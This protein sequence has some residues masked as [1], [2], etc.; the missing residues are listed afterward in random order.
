MSLQKCFCSGFFCYTIM[1][2]LFYFFVYFLK[3]FR[4][5]WS[6]FSID[7]A[8]IWRITSE[9][10]A[11]EVILTKRNSVDFASFSLRDM[12]FFVKKLSHSDEKRHIVHWKIKQKSFVIYFLKTGNQFEFT[13]LN[14]KFSMW[15]HLNCST[16]N[17]WLRSNDGLK[18]KISA[19]FWNKSLFKCLLYWMWCVSPVDFHWNHRIDEKNK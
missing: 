9:S 2:N 1:M 12:V 10:F 13:E 3:D 8:L 11:K 18:C 4:H 15:I 17:Q 5:F 16:K 19:W 6:I 14:W 7:P